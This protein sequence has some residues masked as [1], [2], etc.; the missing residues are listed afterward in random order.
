MISGYADIITA[1]RAEDIIKTI[2]MT[3]IIL[4]RAFMNSIF[5]ILLFQGFMQVKISGYNVYIWFTSWAYG[6]VCYQTRNCQ[7]T[8]RKMEIGKFI[9]KSNWQFVSGD[10]VISE[11]RMEGTFQNEWLGIKPTGE[12]ISI[13]GIDIDKVIDGKIV[14][15]QWSGKYFRVSMGSQPYRAKRKRMKG[16]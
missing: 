1:R 5:M 9:V 16:R 8:L 12:R 15:T 13:T 3:V 10:Y 14:E 11:F 7:K 2:Q 4:A 6:E